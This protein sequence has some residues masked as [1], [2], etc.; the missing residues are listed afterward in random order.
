M[1]KEHLEA[2]HNMKQ[3]MRNRAHKILIQNGEMDILDWL[4]ELD[5]RLYKLEEKM[6]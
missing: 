6:K 3:D 1:S 4:E 5:T 2:L